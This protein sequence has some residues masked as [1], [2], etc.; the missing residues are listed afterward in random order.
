VTIIEV[1]EGPIAVNGCVDGAQDPCSVANC[2]FMS[3]QWNKVNSAIRSTLEGITLADLIDPS[4]LFTAPTGATD[5]PPSPHRPDAARA[6][7]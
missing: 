7:A 5:T 4:Q 1:V 2:C 3:N 6:G